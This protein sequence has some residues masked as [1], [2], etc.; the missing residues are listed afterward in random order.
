MGLRPFEGLDESWLKG[1]PTSVSRNSAILAALALKRRTHRLSSSK[2]VRSILFANT[3][4]A[5][6]IGFTA[7]LKTRKIFPGDLPW[8]M[9]E[10]R[11]TFP[12]GHGR[13]F[14]FRIKKKGS[15]KNRNSSA[16][17]N[18]SRVSAILD[19]ILHQ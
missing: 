6:S 7:I 1:R 14:T 8:S 19:L 3:S 4:Q 10:K 2:K 17:S 5:T 18:A 9:P 11:N 15:I 12:I 13:S 16:P